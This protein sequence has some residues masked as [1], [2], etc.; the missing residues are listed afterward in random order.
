M[1]AWLFFA[2]WCGVFTA[3]ASTPL[4]TASG[5]QAMVSLNTTLWQLIAD[6]QQ[7]VLSIDH[8]ERH[9]GQRLAERLDRSNSYY[10][11][12]DGTSVQLPNGVMIQT[13]D[14][15]LPRDTSSGSTG[16]LVLHFQGACVTLPEVEQR[17]PALRITEIPRGGSLEEAV[18]YS[19]AFPL[20]RLSF[21]FQQK[22]PDCLGYVV[23]N[24]EA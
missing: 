8:V 15:R 10:Q 4:A 3:S 1:R 21:G 13:I 11:M 7:Q 22:R 14:L 23:V 16:L 6:L 17:Y 12:Y 20:G 19:A 5:G 9:L 2:L 18:S 24:G